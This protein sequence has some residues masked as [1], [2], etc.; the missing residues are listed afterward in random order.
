MCSC[1]VGS[2]LSLRRCST[3]TPERLGLSV[4][5]ICKGCPRK[6]FT[7]KVKSAASSSMEREPGVDVVVAAAVEEAVTDGAGTGAVVTVAVDAVDAVVAVVAVV[8]SERVTPWA[9]RWASTVRDHSENSPS[10]PSKGVIP[11]ESKLARPIT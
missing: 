4:I 3:N 6:I 8:A 9:R 10:L 2:Y 7:R 5:A 11:L 1:P